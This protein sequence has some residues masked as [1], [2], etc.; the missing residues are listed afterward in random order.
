MSAETSGAAIGELPAEASQKLHRDRPYL[1]DNKDVEKSSDQ[2]E[3]SNE[4]PKLT[5]ERWNE[6]KINACRF[7]VT[8]Y[9]FIIMGMND[10]C[11]GALIPY[12]EPYYGISY[13]LVSLLFL[14]SFVGYFLAALTNNLVHHH[15]GQRGVAIL[16]PLARLIG[17]IPLCLHP[18]Y[19]AL[20]PI[21]LFPGFGNGIEDSAV[22]KQFP[23]GSDL[24]SIIV[25]GHSHTLNDD[26]I[27][28][29]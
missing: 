11:V 28:P 4:R 16:A 24:I 27:A 14:S 1:H 20:P 2:D 7:I 10:A 21:M 25:F 9:S 29:V 15:L 18:P 5:L 12:I 13:T 17:Y 22:S 6:P 19:A 23:T 3:V 8:N 26:A